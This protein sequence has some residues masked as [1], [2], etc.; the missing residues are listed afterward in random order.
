MTKSPS[1]S[2]VSLRGTIQVPGDKSITH[3]SV[4]F[5]AIAEGTSVVK[6]SI[7]GRDNFA[8][9]RI[10]RQLGVEISGRVTKS[11][12]EIAKEEELPDFI[13]SGNDFC[14]IKINGK[15]FDALTVPAAALNCGNSGTTARLLT[16][17]LA[18][19]PFDC[20][21]SGDESLS[22]RPFKRVVEPLTKMGAQ[23]SGEK[24][25]FTLSG[26]K[27]HGIDHV[28]PHASAQVKSAIIL[29]GLRA[30]GEVSVTEPRLSR[31]HTE[32]M[33]QAMG[34]ELR[35]GKTADGKWKVSLPA[36]SKRLPL[37]AQQIAIPGD[38]SAA[39]F[40]LVAGSV[41]PNSDIVISGVGVNPTRTGLYNILK[42]MGADLTLQN[43]RVVCGEEVADIRV[44]SAQLKGIEVS[45]E[46]VVLAIDEIPILALAAAVAEG[47]TVIRGAA[48]LRVKESDR[49]AMSSAVLRSFGVEVKELPE[50]MDIIGQPARGFSPNSNELNWKESADHRIAMCGT[51]FELLSTG[52]L[53]LVDRAAVE[54]SFPSFQECLRGLIRQ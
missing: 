19:C 26:K 40:F 12:V 31:D 20:K 15:G 35:C 51:I 23:F 34:C 18:A 4:M 16:G 24:M 44:R 38:F 48:E 22:K 54:T 11:L 14:E 3:R 7:L 17:L 42:K 45:E 29:A 49:L 6:T 41:F 53:E 37:K 36:A 13:D 27:L 28:S 30:E 2:A 21:F 39:A 10:M 33:L 8:T 50:G 52:R 5:G 25:P 47:T 46:D 1:P 32:R 43:E 9:I